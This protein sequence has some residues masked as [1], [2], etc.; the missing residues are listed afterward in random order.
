M[1]R[2]HSQRKL[3][4]VKLTR[5]FHYRH[6][7]LWIV[8][9]ICLVLMFNLTF[10]LFVEERWS[11]LAG[12]DAGDVYAAV[13]HSL[14]LTQG[15]EM[16]LFCMAIV[17]L[18]KLTSHRIAGPLIRFKMAFNEVRSGNLSYR[19]KFRKTDRLTEWE[20][21]FNAMMDAI[22]AQVATAAA[23]AKP[24]S[25]SA[26]EPSAAPAGGTPQAPSAP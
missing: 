9:T 21:A 18:A 4:N 15:I 26:A 13:R 22:N 14:W 24:A 16:L 17:I 6:M 7:G 20:D 5:Q 12:T 10:N 3:S 11:Q 2:F 1:A 25:A 19:L 23:A 8:L